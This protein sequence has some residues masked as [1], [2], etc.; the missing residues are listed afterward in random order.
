MNICMMTNTYLPHVGGVARSVQT[1][2]EDYRRLAH[3]VLVVAPTFPD[4]PDS[5]AEEEDHVVR[6]PALQKFNGS[7]FS[8][9]L[10]LTSAFSSR[11]HDFQ[12]DI[13]HSHH[14]FLLGDTALR[15][16]SNA[17]APVV[18]THH[19][20]YEQYTHY[21]PFDSQRLKRF[22]IELSTHYANLCDAVIAPS[23]DI[24]RLI[25]QRGVSVP[26]EVIPTG[27]DVTALSNGDRNRF[28]KT[29]NIP[30]KAFVI[31]HVGRLAPE[32]NLAFL[33]RAVSIFLREHSKA[34]FLIVGD[35]PVSRGIR[36]H[37]RRR[38]VHEQLILAGRQTGQDLIDAYAA[39]DAFAFSSFSETQ[40]MVVAEAMAAG[41]P[42]IALDASGVR[43]VVRDKQ[44]GFLLNARST[45]G[46][47][48]DA[49]QA[50]HGSPQ[51][52]RR[53]CESASRTARKFSRERSAG[54]A[55]KLYK[56]VIRQDRRD[57]KA[58]RA[59]PW[60]GLLKRVQIEWDLLSRKTE[61]AFHGFLAEPES[62]N[63]RRPRPR[64]Q[65]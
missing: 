24:A 33:A 63:P 46:D 17:G 35:G 41:L 34:R 57:R 15:F 2:A 14:P 6:I 59:D 65:S 22:V 38:G 26:I 64:K 53:L 62:S 7:D 5:S 51:L 42:V 19:T 49:L 11:L 40:G 12:P 56:K 48:A 13:V 37:C 3:K 36:S 39:M 25:K 8:V 60:A 1:F 31:G 50:V 9:R 4:Q 16:A 30:P 44:N 27:I 20:L 23:R 54:K 45:P 58:V 55:L 43:E 52:R 32:K 28:R 29:H 10:P 61:F 18:F 47:F 21:V